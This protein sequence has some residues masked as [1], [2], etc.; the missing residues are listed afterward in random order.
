MQ[1]DKR[2]DEVRKKIDEIDNEIMRL[3]NRRME[4]SVRSRQLKRKTTDPGREEEVLANV[5]RHAHPFVDAGFSRR[6]YREIIDE[7][8]RVQDSNDNRGP[9]VSRKGA[10]MKIVILGLGHMGAWLVGELSEHNELAVF[11][12]DRTKTERFSDAFILEGLD[13]IKTFGPELLINAV[14][15]Q[16]TVPVFDEALKHVPK[17]CII[18]DMASIKGSLDRYYA[19]C[20]FKFVSVHPMFGPTFADMDK[21]KGE[22]VIIIRESHPE[23]KAFVRSF[24]ERLGVTIF[25]YSFAEHDRMMAYS[26]TLPFISSMAFASCVDRSVVPG[27]TFAKHMTIAKGLLSEDDSLLAEVL[28]N[29]YSLPELDRVTAMMEYLKHIIQGK[30][31]EVLSDFLDRLRKNIA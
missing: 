5:A 10:K 27:T 21:L 4:F 24:F 30:D 16:N 20:G 1:M 9:R 18:S 2:L 11:D 25:E 26:L 31:H 15:L 13:G 17:T 19:Q 23:G 8:R 29:T 22:S 3:L 6:L 14:T 12:A 7:S 28:F